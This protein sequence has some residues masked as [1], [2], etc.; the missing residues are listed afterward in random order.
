MRCTDPP[1]RCCPPHLT[2]DKPGA[3]TPASQDQ[4]RSAPSQRAGAE[5][6]LCC[7]AGT[8]GSWSGGHEDSSSPLPQLHVH[9]LSY[10]LASGFSE[11]WPD[12]LQWGWG[13]L[14]IQ[15]NHTPAPGVPNLFMF[16]VL[17]GN[18]GWMR[19]SHLL[20]VWYGDWGPR[21]R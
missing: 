8:W 19:R 21:L 4:N 6:P 9:R 13:L 2:K 14:P 12:H 11:L 15:G 7:S 3:Q 18:G 10:L 20:E 1:R 17:T 16:H 5:C